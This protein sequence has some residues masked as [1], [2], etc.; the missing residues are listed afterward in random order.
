MANRDLFNEYI[1]FFLEEN[2]KL[3]LISKN[4][5]KFLWEKHIID[6]LALKYF[7]EKF[8]IVP[9]GLK[10]LDIG[11]GGGFPSV[12]L[13]IQYPKLKIT[14]LDSIKKKINA[15]NEITEYLKLKNIKTVCDR[16][17]KIKDKYDIITS[18]AVA[19]LDKIANYALPLL[20]KGGYFVAYKA[21]KTNDEIKNSEKVLKKYKAKVV[22]IIP[23]DLPLEENH[24]RNLVIIKI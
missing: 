5:E 10:L 20:K 2:S 19:S 24:T 6:S 15:V 16:A 17:E 7:F 18:R 23:Y 22:D 9:D 11:T 1:K 14:G 13:A 21:L 12:P 3:N 8:S 4:D